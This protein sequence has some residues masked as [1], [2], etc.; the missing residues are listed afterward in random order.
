MIYGGLVQVASTKEKSFFNWQKS[1][2][3]SMEPVHPTEY[4]EYYVE[5]ETGIVA[6]GY[7]YAMPLPVQ[8]KNRLLDFVCRNCRFTF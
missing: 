2:Q 8:I 7:Y 3:R 1:I 6:V 4:S 5:S